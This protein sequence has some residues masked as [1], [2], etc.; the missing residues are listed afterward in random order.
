[1]TVN[2]AKRNGAKVI[3]GVLVLTLYAG[4]ASAL[5]AGAPDIAAIKS[6]TLQ[7]ELMVSGLVCGQRDNYNDFVR[8]F[9]PTL[10]GYGKHLKSYFAEI[11]GNVGEKKLNTFVTRSANA[12]S[13]K[14]ATDSAF[15][16]KASVKFEKLDSLDVS[17]YGSFIASVKPFF[18]QNVSA[19][20]ET[21]SA[22]I[23]QDKQMR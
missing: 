3:I 14:S 20:T 2:T 9:R 7:S 5:C 17:S 8:K 16:D 15:C 21:A 12:A 19:C 1:M 22:V 18:P 11:Y 23:K 6:R 13:S 10:V 4:E